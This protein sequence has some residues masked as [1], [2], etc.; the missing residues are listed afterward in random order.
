MTIRFKMQK[1]GK[2][3]AARNMFSKYLQKIK[4]K[5]AHQK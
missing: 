5:E 4:I 1:Q 3:T 2:K